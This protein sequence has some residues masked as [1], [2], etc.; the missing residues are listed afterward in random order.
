VAATI[1]TLRDKMTRLADTIAETEDRE[2]R[3]VLQERLDAYSD[4]M[5][6]EEGKRQRLM[7]E[8]KEAVDHAKDARDIREWVSVV[9]SRADSFTRLEQVTVLH[10]LG[11]Q[12][13]VW[14]E[15]YIHEDGWPQRYKITLHFTGF[16]GQSVTLPA[17]HAVKHD[18]DNLRCGQAFAASVAASS[19]SALMI[20]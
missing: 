20:E 10:A 16:T 2:S 3:H 5:R 13:T 17:T 15:N 1:R 4:Q 19:E 18:S 6:R 7:A 14:N 11:A 9:A 8:A 12:V